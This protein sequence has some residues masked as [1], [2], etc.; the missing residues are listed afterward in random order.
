MMENEGVEWGRRHLFSIQGDCFPGRGLQA[1]AYDGNG[2]VRCG[3]GCLGV[4]GG[5]DRVMIREAG[6]DYA[7]H[8]GDGGMMSKVS[9]FDEGLGKGESVA[10][11]FQWKNLLAASTSSK[12]GGVVVSGNFDGVGKG[13]VGRGYLP[14]YGGP[15]KEV[16]GSRFQTGNSPVSMAASYEP[17]MLD[18]ERERATLSRYSSSV[19][20][21]DTSDGL[22]SLNDYRKVQFEE[23]EALHYKGISH[24]I[25]R[26]TLYSLREL[27]DS[28]ICSSAGGSRVPTTLDQSNYLSTQT[29]GVS[30][31]YMQGSYQ[32]GH[33]LPDHVSYCRSHEAVS[34]LSSFLDEYSPS[35]RYT[36]VEAPVF[37]KE[38]NSHVQYSSTKPYGYPS[39]SIKGGY[40]DSFSVE[41][42]EKRDSARDR[43]RGEDLFRDRR[44][45]NERA[46]DAGEISHWYSRRENGLQNHGNSL[47]EQLILDREYRVSHDSNYT[48]EV[49]GHR[50]TRT[51]Y[52]TEGTDKSYL[53]EEYEYETV[54]YS[55]SY[56]GSQYRPPESE[57][58]PSFYMSHV[59]DRSSPTIRQREH[60]AGKRRARSHSSDLLYEAC[61]SDIDHD[62]SYNRKPIQ[63]PGFSSHGM[64]RQSVTS[65]G[66]SGY[67]SSSRPSNLSR[68]LQNRLGE[69]LSP[70]SSQIKKRL[71]HASRYESMEGTTDNYDQQLASRAFTSPGTLLSNTKKS[72]IRK[73]HNPWVIPYQHAPQEE[74]FGYCHSSTNRKQRDCPAKNWEEHKLEVHP[75]EGGTSIF[76]MKP[77][78]DPPEN[79]EEFKR[80]VR[81]SFLKYL[82]FLNENTVRLRKFKEQGKAGGLKCIVCPSSKDFLDTKAIATHAF[83]SPKVG[84]RCKHLGFHKA[85][86]VL[87]GWDSSVSSDRRWSCNTLSDA[88]ACAVNE[89]FMIWPPVVIIHHSPVGKSHLSGSNLSP[90]LLETMLRGLGFNKGKNKVCRGKPGIPNIMAV[91]FTGTKS[92]LQDAERLHN[93]FAE[94][95]RRRTDLQKIYSTGCHRKEEEGK[96]TT[97]DETENFFGYLGIA[98][99]LDELHRDVKALCVIRS[100]KEMMAK[101][102]ALEEASV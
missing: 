61:T 29:H 92:G 18:S 54:P 90:D 51:E 50:S 24:P 16:Q 1:D 74:D 46:L 86:C 102:Q 93:I 94:K 28:R 6:I 99:D 100:K 91:K 43:Y 72:S 44:I 95:N 88:D 19:G 32:V 84:L 5:G 12:A 62:L 52:E 69:R 20:Y 64:G 14:E 33:R 59:K 3:E 13:S 27:G 2:N 39:E 78:K 26:E 71:K 83:S 76:S 31:E 63:T 25:K 47:K 42:R 55:P 35:I 57:L 30:K 79:T 48:E 70:G 65:Y 7:G 89:D 15:G 4:G 45:P 73:P 41:V 21:R 66:S 97:E 82:R 10:M 22:S 87:M 101:I 38:D 68:S 23:D 9:R 77:M 80:L 67:G 17:L 49:V 56:E 85:L 98:G 37:D 58:D 75:Q 96:A 53:T 8:M 34:T 81:D 11:K 40:T 60:I 36:S